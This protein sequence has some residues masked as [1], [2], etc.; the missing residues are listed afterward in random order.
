MFA[1]YKNQLQV[2]F[3]W[4]ILALIVLL[5]LKFALQHNGSDNFAPPTDSLLVSG[6]INS[7]NTMGSIAKFHLLG[8]KQKLYETA[9]NARTSTL[10]LVLNGT[11]SS[12]NDNKTGYAY[13]S[14][15]KG[16]QK[17]FKVGD[18]IF[19]IARLKEIHDSYIIINHNGKSERISLPENS[20]K[21]H[22][23]NNKKTAQKN[24]NSSSSFLNHINGSGKTPLELLKQQ[25][26]DSKKIK[27]IASS[28]KLITNES[29]QIQG[30][31]VSS[32]AQGSLLMKHGLK[33][34]DIITAINGN[35]ITASNMLKFQDIL[36]KSSTATVTIK[37]NG[38]I[39]NIQ[40]NLAEL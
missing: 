19:S 5:W 27:D 33:S 10:D 28:V 29:G 21:S 26:F 37:R 18:K 40:I 30:L 2:V 23:A 7:S 39:Q 34:N 14:N 12:S 36:T 13:V 31:R 4:A 35:R 32:L 11:M 22:D 20:Q 38:R 8:S 25:K 17:K 9:L 6:R 15:G 3:N 16:E 24:K 1:H